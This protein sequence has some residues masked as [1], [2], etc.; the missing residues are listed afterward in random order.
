MTQSCNREPFVDRRP[1]RDTQ[2]YIFAAATHHES[3]ASGQRSRPNET[4]DTKHGSLLGRFQ[5]SKR[6]LAWGQNRPVRTDSTK[7][8]RQE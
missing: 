7:V 5:P 8:D 4:C 1:I 3:V 6:D 2:L